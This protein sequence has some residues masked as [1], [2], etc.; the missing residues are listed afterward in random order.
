MDVI[1]LTGGIA[2]GKSTVAGRWRELGAVVIDA[3]ALAR[4][5]VA[6]GSA[7]LAAIVERFGAQIVDESGALDRAALGRRIF[8]DASERSALNA[9]VHPEVRRLYREAVS[10]TRAT[11]PTSPIVY[12][13]PLLEEARARDEFG[14]VVVVHAP[15]ETRVRRLIEH[16]GMAEQEA[17]ERVA[18]QQPDDE[19][20]A[21]ADRVLDSS[22]TLEQTIAQA[23]ALWS[24]LRSRTSVGGAE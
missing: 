17:R 18:A 16:R 3:D 2:A 8:A 9:I 12:D 21:L 20:L 22:G 1:A 11:R 19:R 6:P 10:R 14:I 7:G 5:A 24:E 15:T 23:D 4:E 13:V